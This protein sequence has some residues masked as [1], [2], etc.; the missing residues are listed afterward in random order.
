V[1]GFFVACN[2]S[3]CENTAMPAKPIDLSSRAKRIPSEYLPEGSVVM[4]S[5]RDL[6]ASQKSTVMGVVDVATLQLLVESCVH[7]VR[8]ALIH[9][10]YRWH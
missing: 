10:S 2:F 6:S 9:S 8:M 5:E 4:G 1:A 3:A 7:E